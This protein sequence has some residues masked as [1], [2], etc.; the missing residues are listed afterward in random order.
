MTTFA[1]EHPLR[2]DQPD[3]A[4][5]A[6][7]LERDGSVRDVSGDT[8][9]MK[10][11]DPSGSIST[12]TA[13]FSTDSDHAGDG[14]DGWIEFVDTGAAKTDTVGRWK[15]WGYVTTSGGDGPFPS[16]TLSYEVVAEGAE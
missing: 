7:I 10:F 8:L 2:K 4:F 14:T 9:Q 12:E 13:A 1:S 3:S 5:R 15:Y 6:R 16:S 11:K